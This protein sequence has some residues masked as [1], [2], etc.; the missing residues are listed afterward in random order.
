MNNSFPSVRGESEEWVPIF[1]RRERRMGL[2][3]E[4]GRVNNGFR[5]VRGESERLV[6]ICK[7]GE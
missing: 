4:E 5:S 3:L 6:S 1:T 2:L 7:R